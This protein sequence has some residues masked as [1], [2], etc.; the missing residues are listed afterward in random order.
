MPRV[1]VIIPC[2]NHG[3]FIAEAIESV[4]RQTFQD[5]EIIIV[6]DGSTDTYTIGLLESYCLPQIRVIHT[7]NQKLPSAR[8]N[9]I[10]VANGDYILPLDADDKISDKYLEEAVSILDANKNAGIVYCDAEFFGTVQGKWNLRK[11]TIENII[12][13]NIIFCSAFFRRDDWA[14]VGGYKPIMKYGWEDYE[15]WLSI[16]ELGRDVYKIPRTHFYYR[17][18]LVSMDKEMTKEHRV[19]SHV[20]IFNNHKQIFCDN[21]DVLFNRHV[22]ATYNERQIIN[23]KIHIDDVTFLKLCMLLQ[24]INDIPFLLRFLRILFKPIFKMFGSYKFPQ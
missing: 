19:Y 10:R 7:E 15:F 18:H 1:S 22:E 8:N 12:L 3:L 24:R 13:G 5:F 4:L 9:G 21:I 14:K 23:A 6:N 11:Y 20:Q 2:Y 17:Q 16:I